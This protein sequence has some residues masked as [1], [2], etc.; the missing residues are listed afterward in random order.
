MHDS[1]FS[2]QRALEVADLV[3]RAETLRLDKGTFARCLETLAAAEVAKEKAE[4]TRLGLES[5]PV[6][7]IGVAD[8]SGTI[9]VVRKINGAQPVDVFTAALEEVVT[10]SASAAP[11]AT[12]GIF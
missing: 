8:K 7:L 12:R 5:T 9:R 1:M 3:Q 2:D 11:G 4:A 10:T 6:F